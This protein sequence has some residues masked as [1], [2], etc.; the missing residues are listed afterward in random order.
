MLPV[1]DG[2]KAILNP[3]HSVGEI[4]CLQEATPGALNRRL[5]FQRRG[6]NIQVFSGMTPYQLELAAFIVRVCR[7][8]VQVYLPCNDGPL[9]QLALRAVTLFVCGV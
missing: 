1:V 9:W 2:P 3:R 6:L 4:D 5:T 8:P 7:I